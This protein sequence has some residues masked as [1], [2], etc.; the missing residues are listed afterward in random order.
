MSGYID[1]TIQSTENP[2]VMKFVANRPLIEGSLELD[3][4]S[5]VSRVPL[6]KE[7][8]RYPFVSKIFITAN[9]IAIAKEDI[10][11]WDLV[12]GNVVN[13]LLEI[14]EDFPEVILSKEEKVLFYAEKT[15]NPAVVKFVSENTLI[16]GFLELKSLKE[17]QNVPL[18]KKL[19]QDFD[20]V[21]EIFI[22]DNFISVTKNDNINW[23]EAV[24]KIQQSI[25][26][27]YQTG[28][29]ISNIEGICEENQAENINKRAF[30][31][32]EEKI[33]GIL[34]DGQNCTT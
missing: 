12:A 2:K 32:I 3:R 20:F 33:N 14:F 31:E 9:F 4:N 7:L 23:E 21:R 15:P 19:F 18:A 26:E 27:F 6:A 16:N 25:A 8:F 34:Q 1:F 24:P 13:I 30:T 17:A 28:Q 22:N 10:V 5:D 11:E 29:K